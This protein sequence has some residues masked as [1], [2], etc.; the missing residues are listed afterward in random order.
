MAMKR[1]ADGCAKIER[2]FDLA[3]APLIRLALFRATDDDHLLVLVLHHIVTDLWSMNVFLHELST[4][5]KLFSGADGTAL[6][7]LAIRYGDFAQWQREPAQR[8]IFDSQVGYWKDQLAGAPLNI[9]VPMDFRRRPDCRAIG[10]E[11][12][13]LSSVKI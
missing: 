5:Y 6:P 12:R 1:I 10:A 2:P 13:G 7:E 4:F 11:R 3:A 8:Q 9:E